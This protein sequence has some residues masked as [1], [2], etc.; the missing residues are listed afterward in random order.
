MPP[1]SSGGPKGAPWRAAVC[2]AA[3][4]RRSL[5]PDVP[6]PSAPP[7][8]AQ[9]PPGA[10]GGD[11]RGVPEPRRRA[12]A[13]N[14]PR[15]APRIRSRR[16]DWCPSL[17]GVIPPRLRLGS[18]AYRSWSAARPDGR[19]PGG[20]GRN[21]PNARWRYV[22]RTLP[23]LV[24]ASERTRI[25]LCGRLSVEL[26]G[27]ELV[28]SL[29]GSRSR[30]CSPTWSSTAIA[31]VGREELIGA[32]WPDT[33]PRSQDAALRTLLSRLR[34]A[35]GRVDPRRPRRAC[36]GAARARLGRRRGGR[37]A[38][39]GGPGRRW[40]AATRAAPGRWPRSR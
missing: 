7:H 16:S 22:S 9:V 26:D 13:R 33:A 32:L 30:C 14:R 4:L 31:P 15:V 39:W 6:R 25:Q 28:A 37:P 8:P 35:L 23:E 36:P 2:V 5:P 20:H 10:R 38:R 29:R 19:G 12:P 18:A 17:I 27:V 24:P 40:T 11:E 21:L 1:R 34:S 3:R